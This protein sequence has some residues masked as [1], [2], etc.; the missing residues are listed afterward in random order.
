MKIDLPKKIEQIKHNDAIKAIMRYHQRY[1]DGC[2]NNFIS[3]C[4]GKT[5]KQIKASFRKHDVVWKQFVAEQNTKHPEIPLKPSAFESIVKNYVIIVP[6]KSL[7][8]KLISKIFN[9]K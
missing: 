4:N 7:I 8:S 1:L 5:K 2:T 9:I 3:E 6:D